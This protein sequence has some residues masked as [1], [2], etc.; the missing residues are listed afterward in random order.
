MVK[1]GYYQR[2]TCITR[3]RKCPSCW[4]VVSRSDGK[5][6]VT[7]PQEDRYLFCQV[8]R[9]YK[10]R[11]IRNSIPVEVTLIY[12]KRLEHRCK[13]C[14]LRKSTIAISQKNGDQAGCI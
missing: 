10:S 12:L 2:H 5:G 11:E 14:G 4:N 3:T 13:S 6:S 7:L 9:I 8:G 1:I